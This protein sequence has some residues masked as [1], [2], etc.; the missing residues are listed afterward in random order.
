MKPNEDF[1]R[2]LRSYLQ[3]NAFTPQREFRD[4]A[5]IALRNLK[6]TMRYG[7]RRELPDVTEIAAIISGKYTKIQKLYLPGDRTKSIKIN[8]VTVVADVVKQ[9]CEKM[10]VDNPDEYGV[11]IHAIGAPYG[12]LLQAGDYI[13]D[14][15]TIYERRNV[16][17]RL[18]FRRVLW[19]PIRKEKDNAALV[20]MLFDQVSP[21]IANGNMLVMA[22]MSAEFLSGDFSNLLC[23]YHVATHPRPGTEELIVSYRKTMPESVMKLQ[24]ETEWARAL[25]D[26]FVAAAKLSPIQAKKLYLQ[27]A[28]KLSLFGSRFYHLESVSDARQKG[29]A[30]LAINRAGI[31][32]LDPETRATN[33][34]YTFNEIV[35]TRRLGSRATGKHFVDLKLGN[36][37]VQRVTRCETQQGMEITGIISSFIR[38]QAEEPNRPMSVFA[39]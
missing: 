26:K 33:L 34:A 27:L 1:E 22:D 23:L 39:D 5:I 13:L 17:Y 10:E 12:T 4:Q 25:M 6:Q 24:T 9:M 18:Y 29:P 14:T 11:Y 21:D 30:L 32:F 19:G 8:A 38:M 2:Y 15:T 3:T 20:T 37:M 35:S 16:P 28:A 31:R 36:L 7:G